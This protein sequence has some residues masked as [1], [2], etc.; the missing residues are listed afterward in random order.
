MTGTKMVVAVALAAA[1]MLCSFSATG[2]D[3]KDPASMAAIR[4]VITDQIAAFGRDDAEGAFRFATRD[5]QR[6]F[7]TA[8][9]FIEMVRT[10]YSAVY[11]PQ[12]VD[13][14]PLE[15]HEGQLVQPALV[16]GPDGAL[17]E[18]FYFMEQDSAG[19]WRISGCILAKPR[20]LGT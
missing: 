9:S 3:G 20:G 10:G 6:Q 1:F 2:A 19:Q 18:A 11:H 8:G 16:V 14:L 4:Q 12:R 13:F 7:G 5:L 17:V 15:E